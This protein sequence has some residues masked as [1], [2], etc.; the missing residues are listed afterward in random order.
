MSLSHPLVVNGYYNFSCKLKWDCHSFLNQQGNSN[1]GGHGRL[2]KSALTYGKHAHHSYLSS[3]DTYIWVVHGLVWLQERILKKQVPNRDWTTCSKMSMRIVT[4][5]M[6]Q[7]KS[8]E[9]HKLWWK[10]LKTCFGFFNYLI[11]IMC[12]IS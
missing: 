2:C 7:N 11:L 9:L 4:M 5:I 10:W 1:S 6:N 8:Y 3:L 12:F